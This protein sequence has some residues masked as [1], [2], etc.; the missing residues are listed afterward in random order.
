MPDAYDIRLKDDD[1]LIDDGDFQ[2]HA[3]DNQHIEHII[4]SR[5]G[6]WKNSPLTG[7][8]LQDFV[9]APVR[10]DALTQ[11]LQRALEADGYDRVRIEVSGSDINVNADRK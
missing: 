7:A 2:I 1:L 8:G 4:K 11:Q 9:L 3:S 5:K 10:R 6:T